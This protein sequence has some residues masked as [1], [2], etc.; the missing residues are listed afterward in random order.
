MLGYFQEREPP[1]KCINIFTKAANKPSKFVTFTLGESMQWERM[2]MHSIV[3]LQSI[4]NNCKDY[5]Y[6]K[7]C[8]AQALDT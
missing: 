3:M 5:P 1:S 6:S 7:K 4:Q 2:Y 8:Q